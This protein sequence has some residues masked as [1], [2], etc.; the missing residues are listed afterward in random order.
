MKV[1]EL[2]VR[3]LFSLIIAFSLASAQAR[4]V[5][6]DGPE[7]GGD[8]SL[9]K[10]EMSQS[11]ADTDRFFIERSSRP[12]I[13]ERRRE[14]EEIEYLDDEVI[15]SVRSGMSVDEIASRHGTRVL[16][17]T[18]DMYRLEIPGEKGVKAFQDELRQDAGVVS[19]EPNYLV[20]APETVQRSIPIIGGDRTHSDYRLQPISTLLELEESHVLSTGEGVIVAI[21]DTGI[22]PDHSLFS[23]ILLPG[24]DFVDGDGD[25]SEERDFIDNDCDGMVDEAYGHGTHVAGVIHLV[26]PGAAIVPLR[27]LDSDGRGTASS[28]A[29]AIR[30][31]VDSGAHVINLSLGLPVYSEVIDKAVEYANSFR[32]AVI[33]AA[34]NRGMSD[35]I[36]FPARANDAV[37]VAAVDMNYQKAAFSN[38]SESV[39]FAAV[40]ID[41]LSGYP[42]GIYALWDGTSMA[43]PSISGAVALV[44]SLHPDMK[45]EDAVEILEDASWSLDEYNPDFEDLLGEGI[46]DLYLA[47]A[48]EGDD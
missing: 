32:A 31:A 2:S 16:G 33:A 34:G 37:A 42:G 12:K 13:L 26:A 28:V 18:G 11:D 23:G 14:G 46:P 39:D 20:Y 5:P 4:E 1:K 17:A 40:G 29:D 45:P 35:V 38:V 36:D 43:A 3:L 7:R 25:P 15:I 10:G 24:Y 21:V 44:I 19:A 6:Q 8:F 30:E 41:V 9:G 48:G 27:A 47:L 22:D